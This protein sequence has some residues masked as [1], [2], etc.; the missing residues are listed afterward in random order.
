MYAAICDDEKECIEHIEKCLVRLQDIYHDLKWKTFGCAEEVLEFYKRNGNKFDILITDIE[1][2]DISGVE[3]ANSIR[4][5]DRNVII[6]FLTGHTEYA[7][8]C[9]RAEPMNFWVKPVSYEI[10][11]E[12]FGR[13]KRRM[14]QDNE[15]ITITENRQSNKIKYCDIV[16]LE[17]SDRKT[18]IHTKEYDYKTN[19]S[20]SEFQKELS[21]DNF[22]RIYQTYIVNLAYVKSFTEKIVELKGR[23][24]LLPVGRTYMEELK[25]A[26]IRYKERRLLGI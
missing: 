24:E 9:F 7:I 2:K 21:C 22:V 10:I 16:Y 23:D 20:L 6:F 18:I 15:Y 4:S 11:K 5:R 17:K 25:R 26:L 12:D 3:L 19:K 1:M 13:A 14:L 8:Q